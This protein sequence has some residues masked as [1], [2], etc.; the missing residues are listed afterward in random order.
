MRGSSV[1]LHPRSESLWRFG[2]KEKRENDDNPG[3]SGVAEFGGVSESF[4]S[5]RGERMMEKLSL[6]D[7]RY[8]HACVIAFKVFESADSG[9]IS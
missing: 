4:C 7:V 3:V 8:V 5:G 9:V 1:R 6:C 2:K